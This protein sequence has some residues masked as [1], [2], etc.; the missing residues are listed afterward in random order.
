VI[1]GV[2]VL[3]QDMITTLLCSVPKML[4]RDNLMDEKTDTDHVEKA[5]NVTPPDSDE[6]PEQ[7]WTA[8]EE[9]EIV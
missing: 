6:H 4:G 2:S 1:R 9:R 8:E 5:Y 3:Q 7:D